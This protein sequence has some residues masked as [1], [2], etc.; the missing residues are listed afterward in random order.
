MTTPRGY[1][2]YDIEPGSEWDL[3]GALKDA[4]NV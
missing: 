3:E 2:S 4:V 1:N